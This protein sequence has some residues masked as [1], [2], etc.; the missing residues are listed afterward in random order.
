MTGQPARHR[1]GAPRSGAAPLGAAAAAMTSRGDQP[2]EHLGHPGVR[3]EEGVNGHL[4]G[5]PGHLL[6]QVG[7]APEGRRLQAAADLGPS[8]VDGVDEADE[9]RVGRA[10]PFDQPV[11]AGQLAGHGDQTQEELRAVLGRARQ[12]MPGEALAAAGLPA[13]QAFVAQPRF[14]RRPG[15]LDTRVRGDGTRRSGGPC[16]SVPGGR[17]P[18]T[19]PSPLV[20]MEKSAR[21]RYLHGSAMPSMGEQ[22]EIAQTAQV[23]ER[24]P[25]LPGLVLELDL[26][27]EALPHA[28]A[29]GAERRAAMG[30]AVGRRGDDLLGPGFGVALLQL[31]DARV[32]HVAGDGPGDEHHEFA[33]LGDA[34]AA[35]RQVGD[36]QLDEL[37]LLQPVGSSL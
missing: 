5:D 32:D 18:M 36:A 19:A 10:Q 7:A 20:P 6:E 29:A 24:L 28:A 34:R 30:D 8:A 3:L 13:R 11:G 22:L 25:H 12:Q 21:L 1:A 16:P 14:H 31:G 27:V 9:L 33:D 37:V 23:L 26:V 2:V 4:E 17:K 35:E 15:P